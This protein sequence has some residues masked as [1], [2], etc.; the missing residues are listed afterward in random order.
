[1][2]RDGWP[3]FVN[4]SYKGWVAKVREELKRGM[5]CKAHEELQKRWMTTDQ[6][7]KELQREMG[8]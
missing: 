2:T 5:G 4:K 7:L 6:F 8:G 3:N 1:M